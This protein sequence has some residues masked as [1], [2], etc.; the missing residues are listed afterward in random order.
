MG[1]SMVAGH[2]PVGRVKRRVRGSTAGQSLTEFALITP[3]LLLLLFAI[4][5]F[6]IVMVQR[7]ALSFAARQ[8]A[9]AATIHGTEP[10]SDD[11]ICAAVR[12]G[13]SSSGANAD[14]LGTVTIYNGASAGLNAA[15]TGATDPTQE[16]VGTCGAGG[17]TRTSGNWGWNHRQSLVLDPAPPIG[18]SI[19]YNFHFVIPLFGRGL[20]MGDASILRAEPQYAVGAVPG[21]NG[22]TPPPLD[23]STP[24]PTSTPNP[25]A[26]TY[27]TS[28]PNPTP[29]PYPTATPY[30]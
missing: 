5:Q 4:I 10:S 20:T 30:P 17:W 7:N 13:L 11:Q 27:P 21:V 24:Y 14:D 23:T 19:T 18:V 2:A 6:S 26:T 28:T 3:V 29:T 9:R 1:G 25:T 12:A 22:P 15:G 16:E 8:G